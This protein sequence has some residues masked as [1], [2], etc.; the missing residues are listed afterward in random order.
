[1]SEWCH[2]SSEVPKVAPPLETLSIRPFPMELID[3][4]VCYTFNL[5]LL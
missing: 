1:M 5:T 4:R 3:A 2:C